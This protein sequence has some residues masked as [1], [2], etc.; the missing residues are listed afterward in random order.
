MQTANLQKYKSKKAQARQYRETDNNL[1]RQA[2]IS[3]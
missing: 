2:K 1:F 3:N